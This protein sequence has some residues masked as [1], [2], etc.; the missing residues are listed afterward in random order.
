MW[1]LCWRRWNDWTTG[2]VYEG[3]TS[4]SW[5]LVIKSTKAVK[6]LTKVIILQRRTHFVSYKSLS[7]QCQ[8]DTLVSKYSKRKTRKIIHIILTQITFTGYVYHSQLIGESKLE[9]EYILGKERPIRC[10]WYACLL[11]GKW[12]CL[13]LRK[14]HLLYWRNERYLV[15]TLFF[16]ASVFGKKKG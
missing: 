4:V 6:A 1:P 10:F 2:L 7:Q 14:L 5:W 16:R 11:L 8:D 3:M 9:A 12:Q 15:D 13:Q